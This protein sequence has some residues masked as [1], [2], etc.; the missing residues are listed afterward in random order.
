MKW[1]IILNPTAGSGKAAKEWQRT[2]APL[3]EGKGVGYEVF[4]TEA[5]GHATKLVDELIGRGKLYIAAVGG[6]GT[7]HE[8]VNGIMQQES[9]PSDKVIFAPIPMGTGNDWARSLGISTSISSSIERLQKGTPFVQD[10][11]KVSFYNAIGGKDSRYFMNVAG[12]GF[13]AFVA[14]QM[15]TAPKRFGKATYFWEL[16]KS[17]FS[18]QNVAIQLQSDSFQT[19][20]PIFM[21]NVGIGQYL[22]SGMKVVPNAVLDDGLFD[23]TFVEKASKWEVMGQLK[24]LYDGSFVHYHKVKSFQTKHIVIKANEGETLYLQADG[25]IL[26]SAPLQFELMPKCLQVWL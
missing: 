11:G 25:E 22:G 21:L 3:L 19:D 5:A 7:F 26:G 16:L 17:L 12:A 10:V 9:V 2:I 8:V 4:F 1:S 18:F 24:G 15:G 6:D 23:I 14:Q 20:T 13:D